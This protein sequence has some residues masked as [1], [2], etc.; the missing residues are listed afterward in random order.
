MATSARIRRLLDFGRLRQAVSG[1]GIDPRSWVELGR[2]DDDPD[3][4]TWIPGTGWTVDVTFITGEL[5]E[6][7]EIP[8]QVSSAIGGAFSGSFAPIKP[9]C[10]VVVL[11]PA[12]NAN[13]SPTIIGVL[14][15]VDDCQVPTDVN[16]LPVTEE[17]M[18]D[19]VVVKSSDNLEVEF[20]R[21]AHVQ[22]ARWWLIGNRINL[23]PMLP[24]S[25][26][27][28]AFIRGDEFGDA[29]GAFLDGVNTFTSSTATA[30]ST[31]AGV[32]GAAATEAT[33]AAMPSAAIAWAAL[34]TFSSAFAG[35][36]TSLGAASTAFKT[37]IADAP[38]GW[39]S[40]RIDGE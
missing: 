23:A 34:G 19:N 40:T 12:G 10:P 3:A 8:C 29:L 17:V 13:V 31:L 2:V 24:R 30:A 6:E 37:T 26:S 20:L 11:M 32:T 15:A 25:D 38:V 16:L 5:A 22:A 7:P 9:G 18:L 28:Q 35:F 1:P 33:A 36:L 21:D 14:H 39:K 27:T 4:I